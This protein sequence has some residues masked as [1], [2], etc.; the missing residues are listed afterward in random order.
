MCF[1]PLE[2]KDEEALSK[3]LALALVCPTS[4][5][6]RLKQ[7]RCDNTPGSCRNCEVYGEECI[8]SRNGGYLDR[9]QKRRG[10]NV[11]QHK[12]IRRDYSDRRSAISRT[13]SS[14]VM[15]SSIVEDAPTVSAALD[16][17][18]P[19]PTASPVTDSQSVQGVVTTEVGHFPQN[20]KF[21]GIN[22]P[23]VL[24]KM[25]EQLFAPLYT[26]NVME[27]F[28]PMMTFGEELPV[29]LPALRPQ[30]AKDVADKFVQRGYFSS[31]HHGFVLT[32]PP[33]MPLMSQSF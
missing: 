7:I 33:F 11:S 32:R 23:Q 26:M 19:S 12:P 1:H 2:V 18:P 17:L 4:L 20:A 5:T 16:A 24:A 31:R 27:F 9:V 15:G 25:A 22:S 8:I 28:S 3:R 29:P 21:A 30:I 6:R 13:R 10:E 14:A